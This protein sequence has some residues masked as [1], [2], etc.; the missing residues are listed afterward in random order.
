[1]HKVEGHTSSRWSPPIIIPPEDEL[2][3]AAFILNEAK[4]P[5]ILVGQGA[6][7]AGTEVIELADKLGAPVVKALLGRAVVPDD[8]PL[9]TCGLGLLGPTPSQE[10]MEQAAA[11][12]I[13]G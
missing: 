9:T 7:G 2:K 13:I 11:L 5:V 8:H 12:L 10:A 6:L 1:M 3:I 4:K